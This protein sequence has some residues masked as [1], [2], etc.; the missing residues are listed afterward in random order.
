MTKLQC[1]Y[2]PPDQDK[3]EGFIPSLVTAGEDG[4]S[5]M[6]GKGEF[7]VPWYWGKTLAEAEATCKDANARRGI[8]PELADLIVISSMFPNPTALGKA[9]ALALKD[10]VIVEGGDGRSE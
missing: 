9:F 8:S 10:G 5:P 7:A 1:F 3:P 2:V 4:H 6:T